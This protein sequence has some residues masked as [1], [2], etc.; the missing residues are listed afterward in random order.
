MLDIC[1]MLEKEKSS[2]L[3][4][5]WSHGQRLSYMSRESKTSHQ[6]MQ[7]LNVC[8]ICLVTLKIWDVNKVLHLQEIKI[9]DQILLMLLVKT[10]VLVETAS[11]SN[12]TRERPVQNTIIQ[13]HQIVILIATY[14]RGHI[15]LRMSESIGLL[16]LSGLFSLRLIWQV[17]SIKGKLVKRR[18]LR[19]LKWGRWDSCHPFK[20]N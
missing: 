4:K 13:T 16:C 7:Q 12:P 9:V 15:G 6:P 1:D 8:S 11:L 10:D 19:I 18:K 5:G 2:V 3:S 20:I 14:V 17:E